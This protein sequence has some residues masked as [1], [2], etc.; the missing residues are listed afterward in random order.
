[1]C[2]DG[3]CVFDRDVRMVSVKSGFRV[4]VFWSSLQE[5]DETS[6]YAELAELKDLYCV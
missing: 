4:G 1:M 3:V 6:I 2:V 5:Y